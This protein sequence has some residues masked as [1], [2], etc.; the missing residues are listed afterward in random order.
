MSD[1]IVV[2][3]EPTAEMYRAS[4]GNCDAYGHNHK[5]KKAALTYE[6][7]K[8]LWK[9]MLAAAPP[10]PTDAPLTREQIEVCRL[11]LD[12]R[13]LL[14]KELNTLC[15][16]ALQSLALP[17]PQAQSEGERLAERLCDMHRRWRKLVEDE[18]W[19]DQLDGDFD[20]LDQAV[21]AL[22]TGRQA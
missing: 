14:D 13:A 21:A 11:W 8:H 6:S 1:W 16:M 3:T 7:V 12:R 20:T 18:E 5:T 22:R 4:D 10:A 2:P 17:T 9:V 19:G 15:D